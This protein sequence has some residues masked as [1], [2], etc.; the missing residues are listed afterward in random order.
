MI[1]IFKRQVAHLMA[2]ARRRGADD[3]PTAQALTLRSWALEAE[4]AAGIA[5][6]LA[7]TAFVPTAS[8]CGRTRRNATDPSGCSDLDRTVQQVAAV[9]LAGQELDFQ[10]MASL[11]AFVIIRDTV[12]MTAIAARALMLTN[13]HEI[14][15]T[16]STSTRAVVQGQAGR[17]G[18]LAA[19]RSGTWTA[20]ARPG[21]T[22]GTA[23]ATGRSRPR[24]CWW[25]GP[26]RR[27]PGGSPPMPCWGCR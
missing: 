25:R 6:T 23:K 7:P 1:S 26:A 9:L 14:V 2:P 17:G 15:V 3:E 5:K 16:E 10:P 11:R 4:A 27:C 12:A 18:S 13:G 20:P 19:I 22:Q 24:P 8:R 21:C